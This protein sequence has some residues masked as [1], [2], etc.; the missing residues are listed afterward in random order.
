MNQQLDQSLL[1]TK[2][3]ENTDPNHQKCAILCDSSWAIKC[4]PW[5]RPG[6][7]KGAN[8]GAADIPRK[9]G[10]NSAAHVE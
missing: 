9:W 10:L 7:K 5:K 2:S 4:W 8:C 1:E 3:F 6:K